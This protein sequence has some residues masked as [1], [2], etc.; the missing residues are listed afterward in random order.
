MLVQK[1]AQFNIDLNAKDRFGWTPFHDACIFGHVKTVEILMQKSA[2]FNI[3][4][5]TKSFSGWTPLHSTCREG[6]AKIAEMLV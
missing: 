6:H 4:L 2:E 3:E 5:N 1:S